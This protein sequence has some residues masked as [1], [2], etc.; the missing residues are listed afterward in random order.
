MVPEDDG[1]K[2]GRD[3]NELLDRC[4]IWCTNTTDGST[5]WRC[6]GAGCRKNWATPRQSVRVLPHALKCNRLPKETRDDALVASGK[7]SLGAQAEADKTSSTRP[8][9][10]CS[11]NAAGSV[12]QRSELQKRQTKTNLL[13]LELICDACIPVSIVN[14]PKWRQLV[15]HLDPQNGIFV[16][17]TFSTNYIPHEAAR[18]TTLTYDHLSNEWFLS[19][20]FDGGT[21]K[22][23][24]SVYTVHITVTTPYG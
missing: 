17:S 3:A 5:R 16:S 20:T 23:P 2:V 18:I 7:K 11:F 21:L 1:P 14:N 24:Q 6:L 13:T 19:A 10:F 9:P 8:D 4:V 22:C 12:K 15:N